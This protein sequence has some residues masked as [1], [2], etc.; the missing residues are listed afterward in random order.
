[1]N[2]I[3]AGVALGGTTGAALVVAD[4]I[5]ASSINLRDALTLAVFVSGLVWWMG[6]KFQQIEDK[7]DDH[8]DHLKKLPCKEVET[9]VKKVGKK[10]EC[11]E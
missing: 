10:L 8:T 4:V 5:T 7:L 3:I 9:V 6:R 2:N 1:M 11:E